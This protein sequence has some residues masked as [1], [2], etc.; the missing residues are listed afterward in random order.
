MK[1]VWSQLFSFILKN[2]FN[3][4]KDQFLSLFVYKNLELVDLVAMPMSSL[5]WNISLSICLFLYTGECSKG[6]KFSV[7]DVRVSQK[8]PMETKSYNSLG[9]TIILLALFAQK[10]DPSVW[11]KMNWKKPTPLYEKTKQ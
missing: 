7:S 6:L 3:C 8:V 9:R 11:L 4:V 5:H 1:Q 10:T 2:C